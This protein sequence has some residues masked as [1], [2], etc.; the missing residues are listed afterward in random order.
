MKP[1]EVIWLIRLR[2]MLLQLSEELLWHITPAIFVALL[3]PADGAQVDARSKIAIRAEVFNEHA[4]LLMPRWSTR[5]PTARPG[6]SGPESDTQPEPY[7]CREDA[8]R[9][10]PWPAA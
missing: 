8:S 5:S 9:A 6:S 1:H 4:I 2:Y 10:I 3:Q 7:T